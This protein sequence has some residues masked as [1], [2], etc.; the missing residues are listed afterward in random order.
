[1][2]EVKAEA[3]V[4]SASYFLKKLERLVASATADLYS[5]VRDLFTFGGAILAG[6]T[7]ADAALLA[8]LRA[9]VGV[10]GEGEAKRD[11][12]DRA[13]LKLR[14]FEREFL[15]D[16]EERTQDNKPLPSSAWVS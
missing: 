4:W 2:A 8:Q 9:K 10:E 5:Q 11:E 13:G 7:G 12:R 1:M 16:L 14:R 15:K 6:I 3:G